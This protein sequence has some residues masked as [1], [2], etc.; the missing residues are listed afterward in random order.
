[1]LQRDQLS[2]NLFFPGL[3]DEFVESFD[4][5]HR[6][7]APFH[8]DSPK[9]NLLDDEAYVVVGLSQPETAKLVECKGCE[10]EVGWH[11]H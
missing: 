10:S 7:F 9:H 5:A 6:L 11:G 4:F 8:L 1:M 3:A 2:P